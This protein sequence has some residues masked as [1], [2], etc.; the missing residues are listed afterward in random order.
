MTQSCFKPVLTTIDII[1]I[2]ISIVALLVSLITVYFSFFRKKLSF[3]G[4]LTAFHTL[5]KND[6]MKGRFE[7]SLSN[8]GNR[9]LLVRDII[10][11]LVNAPNGMLL[12]VIDSEE[13]PIVLKPGQI[14]LSNIEL[15][16]LF[17]HKVAESDSIVLFN[18]Q[19]YSPDGKLFIAT[20]EI[21]FNNK[22]LEIGNNQWKP[23]KME[24]YS[25]GI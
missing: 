21:K 9:E 16:N 7:F 1:T 5:S 15:P 2:S 20:K 14:V 8:N 11:D 19:V 25:S 10:I 22:D 23:F 3:I 18:F 13:I 6:P 24:K 4:C 12:P 17:L